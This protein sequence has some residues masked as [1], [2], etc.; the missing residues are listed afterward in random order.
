M[1]ETFTQPYPVIYLLYLTAYMM[2]QQGEFGLEP[3]GAVHI[4]LPFKC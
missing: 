1:F 2:S 4:V 3:C